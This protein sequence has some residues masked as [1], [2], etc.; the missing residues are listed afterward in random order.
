MN[1]KIYGVCVRYIS[2]LCTYDVK[3]FGYIMSHIYLIGIHQQSRMGVYLC[4]F[5][6]LL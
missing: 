6:L 5:L 2:V 3:T 4:I 1:Y